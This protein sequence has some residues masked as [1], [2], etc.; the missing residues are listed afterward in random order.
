MSD[1]KFIKNAITSIRYFKTKGYE[2][3]VVSNQPGIVLGKLKAENI[4]L[5]HGEVEKYIDPKIKRV[6]L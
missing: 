5:F 6:E 4:K 2:V 1:T 3:F